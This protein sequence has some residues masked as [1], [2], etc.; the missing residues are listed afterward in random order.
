MLK[1]HIPGESIAL[2]SFAADV[3]QMDLGSADQP[4]SIVKD[5]GQLATLLAKEPDAKILVALWC[6]TKAEPF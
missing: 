6:Q 1:G 2:V 5:L 4:N 3:L